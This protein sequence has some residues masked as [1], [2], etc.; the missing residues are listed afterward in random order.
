MFLFC[1]KA[2]SLTHVSCVLEGARVRFPGGLISHS[3]ANGSSPIQHLRR[4][5]CVAMALHGKGHRKLVT[6][7]GVIGNTA[8][9]MKEIDLMLLL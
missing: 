9:I 6:R 2:N 3:V 7:F 1:F 5:S 8:S 4:Y